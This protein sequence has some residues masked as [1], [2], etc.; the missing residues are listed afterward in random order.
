MVRSCGSRSGGAGRG[1]AAVVLGGGRWVA[2]R[3]QGSA[4]D[5]L[6]GSARGRGAQ[7]ARAGGRV[8]CW[9]WGGGSRSHAHWCH[10]GEGVA[11]AHAPGQRPVPLGV[12][13]SAQAPWPRACPPAGVEGGGGE[14]MRAWALQPCGAWSCG[15]SEGASPSERGVVGA[16]PPLFCVPGWR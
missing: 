11:A 3:D 8:T 6:R 9:G 2:D 7:V 4:A 16:P 13:G 5:G 1:W 14:R 10:R 12:A 15:P